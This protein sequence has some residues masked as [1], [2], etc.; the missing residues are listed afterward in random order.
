MTDLSQKE[1]SKE[2]KEEERRNKRNER[3]TAG[4]LSYN[5]AIFSLEVKGKYL[6]SII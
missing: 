4:A 6:S 1:R 5:N 2:V 3:R